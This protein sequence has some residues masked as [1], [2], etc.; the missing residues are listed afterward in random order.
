VIIAIAAILPPLFRTVLSPKGSPPPGP[1]NVMAAESLPIAGTSRILGISVQPSTPGSRL[2]VNGTSTGDWVSLSLPPR[3]PGMYLLSA[4]FTK[5]DDYGVVQLLVNGIPAGRPQDLYS[6]ATASSGVVPL[7]N[8]TLR[9]SGDLLQV[10]VEGK[11][12]ASGN[13]FF[14]I[15][16]IQL[17]RVLEPHKG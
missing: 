15:D 12:P 6:A 5:S 11:N 7:A 4:T 10:H 9:G 13:Y 14:G 2:F 16:S 8:V 3:A 17:D 1:E